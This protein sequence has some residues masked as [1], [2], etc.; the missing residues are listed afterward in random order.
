MGSGRSGSSISLASSR[1]F[2]SGDTAT[3]RQLE[4]IVLEQIFVDKTKLERS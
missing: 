2:L 3:I 4:Q 1:V